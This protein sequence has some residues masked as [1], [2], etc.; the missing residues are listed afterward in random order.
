MHYVNPRLELFSRVD[1]VRCGEC[2]PSSGDPGIQAFVATTIGGEQTF[3]LGDVIDGAISGSPVKPKVGP[4]K[5]YQHWCSSNG[6]RCF[7]EPVCASKLL[8]Q[9]GVI[10]YT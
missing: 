9:C 2:G 8:N 1:G 10:I 3:G 5:I 4:R 7:P 6:D